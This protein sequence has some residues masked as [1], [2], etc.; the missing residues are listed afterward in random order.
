MAGIVKIGQTMTM[1]LAIKDEDNKFDM[2]IRNCVAHDGKRAPIELVDG[3]GCIVRSKLMTKFTKIKNFGSAA[4]V[5]S[6]AH[7]QAF[8]FPDSMEV[9]F[10]CTIQICKHRCPEQCDASGAAAGLHYSTHQISGSINTGGNGG[11]NLGNH[12]IN[13]GGDSLYLEGGH[14]GAP[15]SRDSVL[16]RP[17][18]IRDVSSQ[19]LELNGTTELS[20]DIGVNKVIRVVSSGDLSFATSDRLTQTDESSASN[21]T[22]SSSSSSHLDSAR[23]WFSETLQKHS[24]RICMSSLNFVVCFAT[25]AALLLTSVTCS[26]VLCCR[27]SH[28]ATGEGSLKKC[29]NAAKSESLLTAKMV[30]GAATAAQHRSEYSAAAMHGGVYGANQSNLS[31]GAHAYLGS[32]SVLSP[33]VQAANGGGSAGNQNSYSAHHRSADLYHS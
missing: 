3:N 27:R 5:L 29:I 18:E 11:G 28:R 21:S 16:A 6:Y 20:K 13:A 2:L 32:S 19:L 4:S 26:L 7:F 25:L 15:P 30:L 1:V 8:K 23:S 12:Q 14:D 33:R 10:Q 31:N 22:V 17:R 24:E 9:H